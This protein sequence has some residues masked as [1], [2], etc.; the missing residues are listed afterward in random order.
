MDIAL[1][2]TEITFQKNEPEMDDIGNHLNAWTDYFT[3]HATVNG[4]S[5]SE[6]SPAAVKVE[7]AE[8]AFTCRWCK[9]LSAVETTGYRIIMDEDIYN[10]VSVNHQNNKKK[11]LKFFCEKVRR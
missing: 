7:N 1:L 9:L 11:T 2:N 5:G 4:E 6:S 10:I 3:C 8:I